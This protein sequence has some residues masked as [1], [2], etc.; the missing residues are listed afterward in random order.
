MLPVDYIVIYRAFCKMGRD[1]SYATSVF[2]WFV[3]WKV[4]KFDLVRCR[5][6][7]VYH[8]GGGQYHGR[9]DSHSVR[10]QTLQFLHISFG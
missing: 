6:L 7:N 5:R 1:E 10:Y 9:N 8:H 2:H 4:S 3:L